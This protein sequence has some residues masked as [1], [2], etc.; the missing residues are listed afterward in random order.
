MQQNRICCYIIICYTD[1]FN[2]L[3]LSLI[4]LLHKDFDFKFW[5]CST[6]S[7]IDIYWFVFLL[8]ALH[9]LWTDIGGGHYVLRRM[10][11]ADQ[12]EIWCAITHTFCCIELGII[13]SLKPAS[14]CCGSRWV[15]WIHVCLVD[16]NVNSRVSKCVSECWGRNEEERLINYLIKERGYNKELRPVKRQ[17]DAVDV[18]LALTL[19]NLISLVQTECVCVCCLEKDPF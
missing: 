7:N 18:Y 3:Q 8:H 17:Q 6:S 9:K 1:C 15:L 12:K 4:I 16:L 2:F 5:Y 19:S 13:C 14:V 11:I 10:Y